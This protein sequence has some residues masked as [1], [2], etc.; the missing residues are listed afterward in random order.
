[1]RFKIRRPKRLKAAEKWNSLGKNC[2]KTGRFHRTA[3]GSR[4]LLSR[5]PRKFGIIRLALK[6]A[7]TKEV[8]P[9]GDVVYLLEDSRVGIGNGAHQRIHTYMA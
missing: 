6:E 5:A 7:C 2:R 8:R 4:V 3:D 9:R 1:M